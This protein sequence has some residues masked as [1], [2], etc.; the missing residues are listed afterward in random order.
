LFTLWDGENFWATQASDDIELTH[1]FVNDYLD[2]WCKSVWAKQAS[3]DIELT[4]R[5]VNNYLG[6]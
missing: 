1:R 2:W 5:F 3:D 6:W 4:H